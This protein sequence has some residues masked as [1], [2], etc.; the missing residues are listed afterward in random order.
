MYVNTFGDVNEDIWLTETKGSSRNLWERGET[1]TSKFRSVFDNV[2]ATN[3][4]G[5]YFD[6]TTA[7]LISPCYDLSRLQNPILKF[8]MVFDIEE[9]WDVLYMEYSTDSGETWSILGSADDPNW[10]NSDFIDPDRP[11]TVGSQWTGT[12]LLPRQYSYDLSALA[13]ETTVVFRFVFASDQSVTGEG[14]AI[15]NFSIDASAVLA[16]DDFSKHNFQLY[17]NPSSS[18]FYI[19]RQGVEDMQIS[20]YDITGRLVHQ[21]KNITKSVYGLDLSRV[22]SGLYFLKVSEGNRQLTTRI[23]KQ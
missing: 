16:A 18:V 17:P 9:D 11:I 5:D 14:A 13:N 2:Y 7:Y 19:S 8:D 12:E 23:L 20:V 10:Y 4:D 1:T 15:D 3:P 6:L 21:E 22:K